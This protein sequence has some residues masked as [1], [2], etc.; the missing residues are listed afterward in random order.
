MALKLKKL[1]K[2]PKNR[3]VKS[4]ENYLRKKKEIEKYNSDLQKLNREVNKA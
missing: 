2:K 1:P 4:M 3:T